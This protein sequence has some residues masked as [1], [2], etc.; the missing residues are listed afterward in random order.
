VVILSLSLLLW[1]AL[2]KAPLK[3]IWHA[4][5]VLRWWQI[6]FLLGINV[7][8][9]ALITARWWLI[10][11]TV[12]PGVPFLPLVWYRLAVFGLSYFTPGPQVGG[13]PL[14]VIYLHRNHGFT[15]ARATSTVIM[16][17]LV[18]FLTN[19]VLLAVGIWAVFQVGLLS[20]Y[21][22]PSEYWLIALAILL[23]WP[24]LHI[25]LLY[26]K[27]LPI[28]IILK[29]I[30]FLSKKSKAI[31]MI[32]VSERLAAVFCRLH[33]RA[34]LVSIGISIV[35]LIGI[36]AE[37]FLM[38]R[39]LGIKLSTIELFAALTF[40]Q[41]A[42]LVPLPGGLGALEASQVFALGMF[43]QPAAVAISLTMLQRVRDVLNGGLGLLIAAKDVASHEG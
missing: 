13:E 12:K 37:Y 28:T 40:L 4:L 39:F 3:D 2:R 36:I 21:E 26:R 43:G 10:A 16:D 35:A 22:R 5:T 8:V 7:M 1:W 11:R 31:R 42:F 27:I 9:I 23:I 17:K 14:Q 38:A 33:T 41:L 32:Y 30:P 6:I 19:F 24:F 29:A 20:I 15:Y 18:E 34:L 25:I